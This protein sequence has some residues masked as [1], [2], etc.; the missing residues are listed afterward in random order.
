MFLRDA[1]L[2]AFSAIVIS[3]VAIFTTIV[4]LPALYTSMHNLNA[5]I[6]RETDFCRLKVRDFW[7]EMYGIGKEFGSHYQHIRMI[8][9]VDVKME[10]ENALRLKRHWLFGHWVSF[11]IITNFW[12]KLTFMAKK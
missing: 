9:N 3:T 8:R 1:K 7:S 10:D 11:K 2:F 6:A 4:I 12:Q 5:E